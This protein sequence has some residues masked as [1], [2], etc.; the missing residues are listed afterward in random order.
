MAARDDCVLWRLVSPTGHQVTCYALAGDEGLA[1][2]VERRGELIVAKMARDL[3]EAVAR[4][5]D[6]RAKL[7]KI[8][9]T[10]P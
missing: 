4:A 8:G 1:V 9:L 7:T 3:A 10:D 2:I 5:T 6:L